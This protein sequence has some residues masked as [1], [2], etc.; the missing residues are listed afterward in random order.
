MNNF[1][2]FHYLFI[3][4]RILDSSICSVRVSWD[5]TKANGLWRL[6]DSQLTRALVRRLGQDFSV[7]IFELR[8]F[9]S[10]DRCLLLNQVKIVYRI[11][12]FFFVWQLIKISPSFCTYYH[13][14]FWNAGLHVYLLLRTVAPDL[15]IFFPLKS[16]VTSSVPSTKV[17]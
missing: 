5:K 14:R 13:G 11:K 10:M 6:Q 15:L 3:I 12:G 4:V 7:L 16:Y 1:F 2:F 8:Y 9:E 17:R